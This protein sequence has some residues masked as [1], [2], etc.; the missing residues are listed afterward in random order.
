M[1]GTE[2]ADG[3]AGASRADRGNVRGINDGAQSAGGE[4]QNG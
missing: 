2:A 4:V 1:L 3:D